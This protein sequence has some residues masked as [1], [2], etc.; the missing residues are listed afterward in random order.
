MR[1]LYHRSAAAGANVRAQYGLVASLSSR[2][3]SA[4]GAA[5][6][7]DGAP[8]RFQ[9]LQAVGTSTVNM[10][11]TA[12]GGPRRRNF[13]V[14]EWAE[15]QLSD[16]QDAL[17]ELR[18]YDLDDPYHSRT[19]P[20]DE[21][22]LESAELHAAMKTQHETLLSSLRDRDAE[23]GASGLGGVALTKE[24]RDA[25]H[26]RLMAHR[27]RMRPNPFGHVK[28][29][30]SEASGHEV[31]PA[32]LSVDANPRKMRELLNDYDGKRCILCS[33]A[34]QMWHQH[35]NF[36]PHSAREAIVFELLRPFCGTPEQILKMW[37]WRLHYS[38]RF[39]RIRELSHSDSR[40]RKKR[41]L[42]ILKFLRDRQVI[43]ESFN[44][45]QLSGGV[46]S[47]GRSWEFERL[48]FIGDNVVK[49]LFNDRINVLFPVHEGG[50]KGKA[51][52][53]QFMIDGNDGLARAYDYLEFNKLTESDRVVSKFKSD[54]METLF[55]ELQLYLWST[56]VDD[57]A[58]QH[59]L[60]FTPE[61]VPLRAIV[62]HAMEELGHVMLM[63]HLEYVQGIV[64]GVVKQHNLNYIRADPALRTNL[65]MQR[66]L[67]SS[68]YSARKIASQRRYITKE[69]VSFPFH[70]TA[71][72]T[73]QGSPQRLVQ[74]V[75]G[76]LPRPFARGVLGLSPLF[77]DHLSVVTPQ[78]LGGVVRGAL[79]ERE[80]AE[81]RHAAEVAAAAGRRSSAA[82]AVPAAPKLT[83]GSLQRL[84][85]PEVAG[86]REILPHI[87]HPEVDTA[88][89]VPV[90]DRMGLSVRGHALLRRGFGAAAL[91]AAALDSLGARLSADGGAGVF[92]KV[93]PL[94]Q[95]AEGVLPERVASMP[96]GVKPEGAAAPISAIEDVLTDGQF[97][98][99][100]E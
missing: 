61:F 9:G 1:R 29:Y 62:W 54:V 78:P 19:R 90:A 76:L 74:Q 26:A 51:P 52:Y 11:T 37:W 99:K 13:A 85:E 72:L 50:V 59:M 40:Q 12:M 86:L 95:P 14:R 68:V 47:S 35:Q 24:Q 67:A 81:R 32:Q 16:G 75:G 58:E 97:V 49:Y 8:R 84:T 73:G 96:L 88:G 65:E 3:F 83:A 4:D 31:L 63:Y 44:V 98:E 48:E 42:Y 25:L 79:A 82:S 69:K 10:P 93:D 64:S 60:P 5:D 89:C 70:D 100:P 39:R 7:G 33:E 15:G 66:E 23:G 2:H 80:A 53:C 43:R 57:G 38:K 6:G 71:L 46:V 55:G 77:M 41:L 34:Y 87:S 36:I 27:K 92:A 94:L 45:N 91:Q 22:F 56:E 18:E 28:I 17:R 21:A 30:R 20:E